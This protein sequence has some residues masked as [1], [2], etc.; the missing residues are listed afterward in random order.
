MS[1]IVSG[2]PNLGTMQ[3]KVW[4]PSYTPPSSSSASS[5]NEGKT[6]FDAVERMGLQDLIKQLGEPAQL[7]KVRQ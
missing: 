6:P 5:S 4:K 2:G 1:T 3:T 7:L